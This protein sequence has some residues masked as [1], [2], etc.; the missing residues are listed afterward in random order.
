M[1]MSFTK[2][3]VVFMVTLLMSVSF[4]YAQ[5]GINTTNP[6]GT[7]DVNGTVRVRSLPSLSGTTNVVTFS[8]IGALSQTNLS[9]MLGS[10]GLGLIVGSSPNNVWKWLYVGWN[11]C[12]VTFAGRSSNAPQNFTFSL[13]YDVALGT[14]YT[15]DTFPSGITVTPGAPGTSS[16]VVAYSSSSNTFTLTLTQLNDGTH[17]AN[18]AATA[19]DGVSWIQ[20]TFSL[21]SF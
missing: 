7:L 13:F 6:V 5:V 12:R 16:F 11:S 15:I 20:G 3:S 14:F 10:T 9:D 21:V 18:V 4:G 1:K 2:K 17:R 19:S 8:S